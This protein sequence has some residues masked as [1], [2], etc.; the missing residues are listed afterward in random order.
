MNAMIEQLRAASA[1][2]SR[3]SHARQ[4]FLFSTASLKGYADPTTGYVGPQRISFFQNKVNTPGQGFSK[5]VHDAL[6]NF[7]GAANTMPNGELYVAKAFGVRIIARQ[8]HAT[9]RNVI[10]HLLSATT[11]IDVR[12]GDSTAHNLGAIEHWPCGRFGASTRAIAALGASP[13]D[14]AVTVFDYPTNGDAGLRIFEDGSEIIFKGGDLVD[15]GLNIREGF[16][17]TDNGQAASSPSDIRELYI[18]F[19]FDGFNLSQVAG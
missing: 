2:D 1:I 10:D 11:S 8:T 9:P 18:Q 7:Q 5:P 12:R 3:Y 15:P 19:L 14:G 16:Y 17:L 6:T 13:S 4:K